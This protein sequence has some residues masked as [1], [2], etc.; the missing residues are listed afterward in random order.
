[1]KVLA[2]SHTGLLSGAER[3]L[4]GQLSHAL[5]MGHNVTLACAAG[6]LA[7]EAAS[8]GIAVESIRELKPGSGPR[9]LALAGLAINH[10][11]TARPLRKL[12]RNAD[13]VLFNSS[14]ALPATG[15]RHLGRP[16]GL[17][18]HDVMIRSDRKATLRLFRG[19]IDRAFPV[20]NAAAVY[21][22]TLGIDT[23]VVLNGARFEVRESSESLATRSK[24][25]VVVGIVAAITRWKGHE[26][27]LE[28]M[29]IMPTVHLEILG[30]PFP[31]DAEYA[32]SLRRR[33]EQPD[34]AGRVHFLGHRSDVPEVMKRWS[35]S[36]S[37]SIEPEAGPLVVLESMALAIPVVA[38]AL[39]GALELLGDAGIHVPPGDPAALATAIS[40]LL[41][42]PDAWARCSAAG[43]R[44]IRSGLS[45]AHSLERC[46]IELA[47]LAQLPM[48]PRSSSR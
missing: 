30:N 9:P 12:A 46:N 47:E 37:A 20:S 15:G 21:A 25:P 19:V 11:L 13:V 31:G 2:V 24:D 4:L 5:T 40:R 27:L 38:T 16:T 18:V 43:P 23:R 17:C 6:P 29:A 26:S 7:I 44:A 1:M 32:E 42:D 34:L 22:R 48:S 8:K 35:V 10:A 36:I 41:E 45:L 3:V 33:A 14:L 39:G 28:A